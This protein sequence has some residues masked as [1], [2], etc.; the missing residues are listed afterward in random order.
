VSTRASLATPHG[1]TRRRTI[2]RFGD[3]QEKAGTGVFF[4][5]VFLMEP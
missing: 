3:A 4:W 1:G 2:A 5:F